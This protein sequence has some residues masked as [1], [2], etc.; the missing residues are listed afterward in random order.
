MHT[1]KN[2]LQYNNKKMNS[3]LKLRKKMVNEPLS[4]ESIQKS[5]TS[6]AVGRIQIKTPV[7]YCWLWALQYS[8]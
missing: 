2:F 5:S 4:K 6:L 8:P 3:I 1:Y 7:T